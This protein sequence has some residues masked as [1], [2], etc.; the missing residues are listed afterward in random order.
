MKHGDGRVQVCKD[1]PDTWVTQQQFKAGLAIIQA[2]PGP[3]FNLSAYLGATI[4]VRMHWNP[5]VGVTAC[6]LGL[7]GPGALL[8]RFSM[9][10][11]GTCN[12]TGVPLLCEFLLFF[13]VRAY[14]T[15]STYM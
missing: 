6:W 15:C 9:S 5:L 1:D 11:V 4:A 8:G 13:R 2:M 10:W 3:M 14:A 7:F 12:T